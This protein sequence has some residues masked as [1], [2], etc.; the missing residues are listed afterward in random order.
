MA[1]SEGGTDYGQV[2]A[3]VFYVLAI[4]D[5]TEEKVTR[6]YYSYRTFVSTTTHST[7]VS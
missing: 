2:R 6:F 5:V 4:Y 7:I 1:V 3:V